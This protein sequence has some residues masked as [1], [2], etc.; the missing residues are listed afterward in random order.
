MISK[1]D[2]FGKDGHIIKIEHKRGATDPII[3]HIN[4]DDIVKKI[5]NPDKVEIPVRRGTRLKWS[6]LSVWACDN[7]YYVD[8]KDTCPKDGGF[9]R[10]SMDRMF[11]A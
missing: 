10:S 9:L 8:G 4:N 7:G 5:E 2:E 11:G 6:K 1:F 3:V